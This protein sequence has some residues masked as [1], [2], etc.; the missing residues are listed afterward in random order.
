M[1]YRVLTVLIPFVT[2]WRLLRMRSG[3]RR[4]GPL[5]LTLAEEALSAE[6]EVGALRIGG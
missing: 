3:Y 4:L 6:N 1:L 5:N 2:F